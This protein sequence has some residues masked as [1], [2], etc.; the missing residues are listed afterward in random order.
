VDR[1]RATIKK[2]LVSAREVEAG[3]IMRLL[4]GKLR[5]G[6]AQQTVV[7]ALAHAVLLQEGGA[8]SRFDD[9]LADRLGEADNTLKQVF[10]ECPT[11]N[12]IVPALLAQGVAALPSACH[13]LPGVPVKPML[14]KPTHG[15]QLSSSSARPHSWRTLLHPRRSLLSPLRNLGDHRA[16]CRG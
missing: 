5:I 3:Y 8:V 14:A 7:A 2:L 15:E 13:F 1:K 16:I 12:L 9:Q 6:L 4:Q 11:W 10:S